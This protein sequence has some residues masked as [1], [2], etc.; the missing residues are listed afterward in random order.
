MGVMLTGVTSIIEVDLS[1]I[2]L[3]LYSDLVRA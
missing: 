2:E 3:A 1:I